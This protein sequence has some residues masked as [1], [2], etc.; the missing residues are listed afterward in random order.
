LISNADNIV[1]RDT[2]SEVSL[3]DLVNRPSFKDNAD[4]GRTPLSYAVAKNLAK[5]LAHLIDLGADVSKT[6]KGTFMTNTA[7][8]IAAMNQKRDGTEMVRVLLSKGANADELAAAKIDEH[9]LSLGMR[10]WLDKSRR[11]GVPNQAKLAHMKKTPPMDRLHELDYAVV[12]EE[13]AVSVI[14]EALAGRFGNP[15]GNRKPLVMLLLG[16]PGKHCNAILCNLIRPQ[17]SRTKSYHEFTGHGKTYFSS[18]AARSLVGEDNFLF[19][20]CQSIRDDA[21]LFGSRLGGAR[22]GSYS[23]DGQL[24]HW[25]RQRQ[26][27]KCII[28]LDEF[29]KMQELTSALGWG[30]AKKIYQSFLEP[31]NDGTLSDQGAASGSGTT[32]LIDTTSAGGDKIDC[33]QCIWILTSNWG[34]HEI[35]DFCEKNKSRMHKKVDRKDVAWIQNDLVKKILRPLC[36][37]EFGSVHEDVKAL[38]RRIDAIVPFVPFTVKERKVVADTAL[39]ER[40][41]L[42]REPCVLDGPEEKRRSLGNL[43]LH[44]TKAFAA[45]AADLY[46]PMQGANGMIAAVQ[47]VDGQFQMMYLRDQLGLTPEQETRLT[48]LKP[49]NDCTE[50]EFWVHYDQDTAEI[51]ITQSKPSDDECTD[52]ET[53]TLT[54]SGSSVA[55]N[56]S[57]KSDPMDSKQSIKRAAREGAS[58]DAF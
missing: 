41:S 46:D 20:P 44:S 56:A 35:I 50:P 3:S 43:R 5:Q 26:K 52:N 21:D 13:A 57:D 23:S 27:K 17:I 55:D 54:T 15:Q 8:T 28:F 18:N 6:M 9:L 36:I 42:Y 16:P 37:R 49:S 1:T 38:C 4:E 24:T 34:Q 39:T 7:L 48:A 25:L 2:N 29:E 58:N 32:N 47:Q 51:S 10:Y 45:Y 22:N 30:Q 14:Q 40:F 53:E 33:T 19:I 11:V 12:G 31:W